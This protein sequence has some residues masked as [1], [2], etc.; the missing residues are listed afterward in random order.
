M[1]VLHETRDT[2]TTLGNES[3][4]LFH[5]QTYGCYES[6]LPKILNSKISFS[7]SSLSKKEGMFKKWMRVVVP[8][9]YIKL[10]LT[11]WNL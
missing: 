6:I 10:Q 1:H 8:I 5:F 4:K 2:T 11:N 7:S 3:H 9:Q